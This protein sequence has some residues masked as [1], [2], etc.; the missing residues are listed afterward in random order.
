MA[1]FSKIATPSQDALAKEV[2]RRAADQSESVRLDIRGR[3]TTN[4]K[5]GRPS[6]RK[7]AD[8]ACACDWPLTQEDKR[9]RSRALAQYELSQLEDEVSELQHDVQHYRMLVAIADQEKQLLT[10]SL[11]EQT[12]KVQR[13]AA[14][15][16][17]NAA[18]WRMYATPSWSREW[19]SL[20]DEEDGFLPYDIEEQYSALE[21]YEPSVV[22]QFATTPLKPQVPRRGGSTTPTK[23]RA[24]GCPC[25]PLKLNM[26]T[27]A[28]KASWAAGLNV[29]G[30]S[31]AVFQNQ[32][33]SK[34]VSDRKYD[35]PSGVNIAAARG[36]HHDAICT[37]TGTTVGSDADASFLIV[38]AEM[39]KALEGKELSDYMV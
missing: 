28:G 37:S 30:P 25:T 8:I 26:A 39:R 5:H 29:G 11:D 32:H 22:Q 24:K 34:S 23:T 17:R 15:L 14:E 6:G 33:V 10:E 13:L 20:S 31:H 38:A 36:D 35:S 2:A 3:P 9:K 7:V 21:T 1:P 4:S 27:P 12:G 19:F 18:L 16:R